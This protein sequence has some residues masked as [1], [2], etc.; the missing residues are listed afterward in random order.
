[1]SSSGD[2]RR[3]RLFPLSTPAL[4]PHAA[5]PLHVFEPRYRQMAEHALGDDSRI[6]M[7]KALSGHSLTGDP[8]L[9]SVVCVGRILESARLDDGRFLIILAG[10]ERARILREVEETGCL[11][12]IAEA[13]PLEEIADDLSAEATVL[14][15]RRLRALIQ[16]LRPRQPLPE[17]AGLAALVDLASGL[18]I[19]GPDHRQRLLETTEVSKRLDLFWELFSREVDDPALRRRLAHGGDVPPAVN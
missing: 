8:P 1:M 3:V 19:K 6:A 15:T 4:F 10:E 2:R 16:A 17:V 9:H 5:V 13:Q 12:R 14:G 7:A 11:Y 18:I